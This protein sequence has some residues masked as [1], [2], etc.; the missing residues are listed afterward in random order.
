[1]KP[2][3]DV[4]VDA[5]LHLPVRGAALRLAVLQ[6]IAALK[7][8]GYAIMPDSQVPHEVAEIIAQ[9]IEPKSRLP[10]GRVRALRWAAGV[11]RSLYPASGK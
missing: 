6:Q 1:M 4:L 8:A 11:A 9:A 10:T 2:V 5:V 7:L 3:E